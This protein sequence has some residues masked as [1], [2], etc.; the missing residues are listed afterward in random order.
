[1]ARRLCLLDDAEPVLEVERLKALDQEVAEGTLVDT[2]YR[3]V[4]P[5]PPGETEEEHPRP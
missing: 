5:E 2:S 3:D 4:V 1:M